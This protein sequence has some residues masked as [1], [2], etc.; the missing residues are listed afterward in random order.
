MSK[1]EKNKEIVSRYFDEYWV[2]RNTSIV[3]EL[4]SEDFL[5]SY[6]NHGAHR[7]KTAA[8]KMLDDFVKVS[9]SYSASY[10]LLLTAEGI[11]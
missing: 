6:P 1:E 4:C 2:K 9:E 10:I 8:K 5:I 3:D 7:G 11:S